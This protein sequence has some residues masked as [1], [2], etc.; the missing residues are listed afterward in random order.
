MFPVPGKW[1]TFVGSC[2]AHATQEAATFLPQTRTRPLPGSFPSHLRTTQRQPGPGEVIPSSPVRRSLRT[3]AVA[4][5]AH[6]AEAQERVTMAK[7]GESRVSRVSA[8][9]VSF[10]AKTFKV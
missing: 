8:A 6:L 3:V 2:Q 7:S 1:Q 5:G 9:A 10:W 4:S